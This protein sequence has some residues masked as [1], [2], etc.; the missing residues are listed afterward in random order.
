MS[1]R[2]E[3]R[4]WV[5]AVFLETDQNKVSIPR[6]VRL[7]AK[8]KL[9]ITH[10]QTTNYLVNK[11]IASPYVLVH[12]GN[13]ESTRYTTTL[14]MGLQKQA[15]IFGAISDKKSTKELLCLYKLHWRWTLTACEKHW[16]ATDIWL[17][18]S[19]WWLPQELKALNK[20]D[21]SI[22]GKLWTRGLRF[23]IRLTPWKLTSNFT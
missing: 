21:Y 12:K 8:D 7:K 10:T 6:T 18:Y 9:C 1:V 3:C 16:T 11:I 17:I 22:L 15:S 14:T 5:F 4:F 20:Q 23:W 19:Q 2:L 13:D